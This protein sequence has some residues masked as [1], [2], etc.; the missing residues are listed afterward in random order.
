MNFT[1]YI[2]QEKKRKRVSEHQVPVSVSIY[3]GSYRVLLAPY[4]TRI[5]WP[6]IRVL[7]VSVLDKKIPVSI[8]EKTGIFTIRILYTLGIPDPF[9]PL[10]AYSLLESSN[11]RCI[12]DTRNGALYLGEAQINARSVSPG[13]CLIAWRWASAPCC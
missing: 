4:P 2:T 5:R 7:P 10:V 12:E 9:S 3:P 8:S 1:K 11:D 6:T 13:F